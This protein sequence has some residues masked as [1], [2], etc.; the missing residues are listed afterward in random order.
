M[1]SLFKKEYS[2]LK[3]NEMVTKSLE[4]WAEVQPDKTFVYYGEEKLSVTFQQ[5]NRM[6]NSIAHSLIDKGIVKGDR[7]CVFMKNPYITTL[8]MFG[9][10]KSG[11][12][13]CPVNFNFEGR[14]L[15]YQLKD[16]N[17]KIL[18]TEEELVPALKEISDGISM[19]EEVVYY[20]NTA[21]SSGEAKGNSFEKLLENK[22]ANPEVELNFWD[23][24]NIIY[25][26]GTT[27][28]AK[29]VVQ[30]HRWIN[31]YT[32]NFRK[33]MNSSDVVYNDLPLY[34]VGGAFANVAR[35]AYVGC[36]IGL[37]NKF[38][39]TEFWQRIDECG[40]SS[41]ILLDVMIPWL[42]NAK[43]TAEDKKNTLNKVHMQ[44]LPNYHHKVADRFGFD[45]VSAGFGQTESGNPLVGLIIETGEDEGTPKTLQKGYSRAEM[46]NRAEQLGITTI[47]GKKEL[48]KGFMGKP[49]AL[50]DVAILNERDEELEPGEMGQIALRPHVPDI[51]LTEYFNKPDNTVKAMKNC[52]F[53][54][55]DAGYLDNDGCFYFVDRL[56]DVIRSRGEKF[57]SYQLEDIINEHSQVDLCAAF[58]IPAEVG[59]EDE[60][61]VYIVLKEGI[62]VSEESIIEW[63]KQKTP[64]FMWPKVIR[65]TDE[66]PRTPSNKIQKHQLR[67]MLEKEMTM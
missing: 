20:S 51:V 26:S 45:Y 5:F 12:V 19:I 47:D 62:E 40:A 49:S 66:L 25:T 48:K 2:L 46:L 37:W 3:E 67:K 16:T 34:H 32:H 11:A 14:L 1:K 22:S 43:P 17:P 36:T 39:P 55:G 65:F 52:W 13:F 53:H 59:D 44:P 6:A 57:S 28:P 7:I 63:I 27:G 23:T 54:T 18:L 41:A 31:G 56:G 60:A 50:F 38:S 24:A 33:L 35:A 29:G 4:H 9:I 15:S 21:A 64:K 42:M 8:A 30:S 61:A 58:P 10:W